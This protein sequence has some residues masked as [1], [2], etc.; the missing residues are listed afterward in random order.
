M[1]ADMLLTTFFTYIFWSALNTIRKGTLCRPPEFSC[2]SAFSFMVFSPVNSNYLVLLL[3][4]HY[5]MSDSLKSHGL[6]HT[7]LPCPPLS[8]GV[9]SNSCPLSLWCYL[10]ILC[11]FLSLPFP[12]SR[13]FPVSQL[14]CIRLLK[15][16][17]FS[18]RNGPSNEYSG[19]ISFRMDWLDLLAFEEILKSLLQHQI[20]KHQFFSTQPSL[21]NN[22]HNH[23]WLLKKP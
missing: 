17:S 6:Q 7:R 10:T 23:R 14:F 21:R 8:P 1:I 15:I 19:L 4:I 22:S 3:F 2:C 12:A 13:S 18:F 20:G 9:C 16:W 11:C 5:V